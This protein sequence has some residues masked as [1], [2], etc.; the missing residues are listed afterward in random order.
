MC[1]KIRKTT[2]QFVEE[3]TQVHNNKYKYPSTIYKGF[4]IK[5]EILCE[6]HGVFY[7]TP[8]SHV[9]KKQGCK[10]C[11]VDKNKIT[12][13]SLAFT[14]ELFVE[15]S[16]A[17]HAKKFD[18]SK[19]VYV[20]S[21]TPVLIGCPIHGYNYIEPR[22]HYKG[23]GCY[24]CGRELFSKKQIK[25]KD[26]EHLLLDLKTVHKGRFNYDNIVF[27]S[28]GLKG[29]DLIPIVCEHHGLFIQSV[30][31]HAGG[32]GCN[33]CRYFG[34]TKEA[35]LEYCKN[36][37]KEFSTL[38]LLKFYDDNEEF[39]KIGI[40]AQTVKERY[41]KKT[42]KGDYNYEIIFSINFPPDKTWDEE[43]KIK[44]K[45]I[46]LR[47]KPERWF[48]GVTECFTLDLPTQEI[49]NNLK[50]ITCKHLF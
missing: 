36:F 24:G 15:K 1:K 43:E 6:Q 25:Y 9:T 21:N 35:Y 38:Y 50:T 7:Q 20:N 39:Y 44:N 48:P 26:L 8:R 3:A 30:R 17:V 34:Y 22:H 40:T 47:Y 37:N 42:D 23:S 5:V 27:P 19:V 32:S 13:K 10:Q 18:Y 46:S 28:K 11:A 41:R 4:N 12:R 33:S 14:K 16:E 29:S 45:F 49:I 2:E 31:S